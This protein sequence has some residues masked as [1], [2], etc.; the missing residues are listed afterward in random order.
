MVKG[1]DAEGGVVASGA[2]G[3]GAVTSTTS[4]TVAGD[5]ATTVAPE[6]PTTVAGRPPA[7]VSVKVANAAGTSG[8][9]SKVRSTLQSKGYSQ[10]QVSDAPKIVTATEI[11]FAEGGEADAASVAAALG[12]TAAAKPMPN[13]P[14]LALGGAT[15]LVLAGPDLA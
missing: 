15:V 11:Y 13:P 1:Y 10:I 9:A 4:T 14:P 3:S 8:L 6:T 7:E 2:E 12:V 5:P